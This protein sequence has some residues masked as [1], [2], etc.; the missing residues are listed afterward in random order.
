MG[1][2]PCTQND[3]HFFCRKLQSQSVTE[4]ILISIR[5]HSNGIELISKCRPMSNIGV[6]TD[7]PLPLYQ[8][9]FLEKCVQISA[10]VCIIVR[11]VS[12]HSIAFV[13]LSTF[14][15]YKFITFTHHREISFGY[16]TSVTLP[17]PQICNSVVFF[18]P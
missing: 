11:N 4:Q 3:L 15:K 7:L 8:T 14:I 16:P 17:T 12:Y 6:R 2:V 9:C 18:C 5:Q 10:C 13:L 1:G